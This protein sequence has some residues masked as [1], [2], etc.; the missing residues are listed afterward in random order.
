MEPVSSKQWGSKQYLHFA[1]DVARKLQDCSLLT[2]YCFLKMTPL[3]RQQQLVDQYSAIEDVQERM[4]LILDRARK[5]PPLAEEEKTEAARVQGCVSRVWLRA[6]VADRR[7]HFR[8]D[9]DSALVRGLAAFICE[10]YEGATPDEVGSVE[11]H[12]L[13]KLGIAENLS[14]TRRHGLGQV[15]RAMC[16]FARTQTE[17]LA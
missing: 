12:L 11:P 3:V 7:C 9:A 2:T 16:D 6:S 10:M 13:E 1:D 15:W 17:G 5:L 4:V 14:P 8:V